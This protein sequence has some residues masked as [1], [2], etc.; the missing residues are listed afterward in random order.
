MKNVK[1]FI[2]ISIVLA[3]NNCEKEPSKQ[4]L[5]GITFNHIILDG[6]S[7]YKILDNI[8]TYDEIISYDSSDHI[9][10]LK[11]E[12][13]ERIRDEKYPATPTPF[14]VSVDGEVIYIAN[15]IPGYSS[16]SCWECISVEPYSYD[17]KFKVQVGYPATYY[18]TGDDPR[19]NTK[20]INKL[21]ADKKLRS[22][23]K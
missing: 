14:A 10:L 15:F 23:E 13:G 18:F 16:L 19:N 22:I 2:L 9:F 7:S 8:I 3:L 12:A 1:P 6:Q 4:N 11:N 17:N 21:L 5:K 20:I